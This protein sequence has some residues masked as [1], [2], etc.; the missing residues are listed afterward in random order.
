MHAETIKKIL[1]DH[2]KLSVDPANLSAQD[3]LY[4]SGL[5]SLTTVNI[6]L[7]IEDE[8]EVEFTDAM[9]SRKTF[10]TIAALENAIEDLLEA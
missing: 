2:G 7:A 9:L 6:M 10:Q 1:K 4:A 5:T 8:F 3:D